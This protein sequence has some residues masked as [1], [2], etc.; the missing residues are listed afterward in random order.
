[1][2]RGAAKAKACCIDARTLEHTVI[3]AIAHVDAKPPHLAHGGKAMGQAVVCLLNS[4]RLL[5][6]QWLHNPI[7]IVVGQVA[8]EMQVRIDQTR[9]NS[10][11]S[12]IN[13]VVAGF[14]RHVLMFAC[15]LDPAILP[16]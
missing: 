4:D 10:L 14:G 9:H 2:P 16:N 3:D 1:M 7:G 13:A 15:I 6:Q 11:S 8:R 12:G 5:F